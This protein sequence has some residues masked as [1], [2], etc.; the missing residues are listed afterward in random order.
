MDLGSIMI[1]A[2][3]LFLYAL[4]SGPLQG[5]MVTAPIADTIR[6]KNCRNGVKRKRNKP[7]MGTTKAI[8]KPFFD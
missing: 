5:T 6:W 7:H 2:G 4:V 3:A 8:E 1:V